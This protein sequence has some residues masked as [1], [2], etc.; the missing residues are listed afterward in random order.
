MYFV[1]L[2]KKLELVCMDM[3]MF[4]SFFLKQGVS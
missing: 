2:K 3:P 4:S 1:G